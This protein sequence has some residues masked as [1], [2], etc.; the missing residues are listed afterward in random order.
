MWELSF[1]KQCGERAARTFAQVVVAMAGTT[2]TGIVPLDFQQ[3]I[4]VAG[5]SAALSVA[6]S[7]AATGVGDDESPS[8]IEVK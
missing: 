5:V 3:I 2:W 1:W 4:L 6:T 8:L 7:I